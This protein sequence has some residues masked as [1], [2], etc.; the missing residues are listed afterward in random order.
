MRNQRYF[1]AGI[2]LL[3]GVMACPI[4]TQAAPIELSLNLMIPSRHNR[5]VYVL[6][7]WMKMVEERCKG[8]VKI[9]PYFANTLSPASEMFEATLAGIADITENI[10]YVNPGLFPLTEMTMLP[11]LGSKTALGTGRALWHLY[12]TMPEFQKEYKGA[13]VLW[14][15]SSSPMRLLSTKKPIR[16]AE[17]LKNMKVWVSGAAPVRTG[18]A[19]GFSPV[20]MAPGDVYVALEKGVIDAGMATNEIAISRK[21]TEVCKYFNEIEI[22]HTPFYVIINQ[23]KWDSLPAE[24]KKVF[25]ELTGDWAVEFTGKLRDKEEKEAEAA[26]KAQGVEFITLPPEENAKVRKLAEPVKEAYA[27]ELEAKGLPGKKVLQELMKPRD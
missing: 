22:C 8:A 26:I 13:K 20:S 24:V 7:P 5:W 10:T 14:L 17:D 19:M 15:H 9:K 18:K 27:A 4:P 12:K 23:K 6:E 1:T 3:I 16:K 2:L 25:E 11:D 21:F